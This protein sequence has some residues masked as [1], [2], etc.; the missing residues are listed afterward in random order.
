MT[1]NHNFN[2]NRT[3][4]IF[5]DGFSEIKEFYSQAG[6][7]IF[8]LSVLNGK[9]NGKFLDI[10]AS[11]PKLINNTFLLEN[12]FNWS[13]ILIEIDEKLSNQCKKERKS[14]VICSDATKINYEEIFEKLGG[15]ID[16]ISLDI[17]GQPTI[18]V[19]KSLPLNGKN[20]GIITFEHDSYRIGNY[21]KNES[22]KIFNKNG[23][24]RLCEDV[25][26]NNNAYEDWYISTN[27]YNEK[28]DVLK[29]SNLNWVDILFN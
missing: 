19:L 23:F 27:I 21:I 12:K 9:K 25:A 17:D 7:D 3:L 15:Y 16:Y 14:E 26:N 6:Q 1:N 29:S 2:D 11:W 18:D 20:V 13:G 5:F 22:R 10:G 28:L 8:I 4:K 24:I